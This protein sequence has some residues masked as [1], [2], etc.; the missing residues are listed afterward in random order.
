MPRCWT[1]KPDDV[2]GCAVEVYAGHGQPLSQMRLCGAP[3]RKKSTVCPF[4]FGMLA[5]IR[6]R[7]NALKRKETN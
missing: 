7:I 4:H 2:S 5:Q 6:A 1:P 3:C